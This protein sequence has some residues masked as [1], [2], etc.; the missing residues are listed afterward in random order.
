M[1]SRSTV[2]IFGFNSSVSISERAAASSG[3]FVLAGRVVE[4]LHRGVADAALGHVDDAL[5]GQVV[6]GLAMT[7][8]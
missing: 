4:H 5:E 1:K 2:R 7:R 3:M 6:G 8:R